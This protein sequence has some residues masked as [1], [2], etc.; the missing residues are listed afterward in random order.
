MRRV[1]VYK[2]NDT[3]RHVTLK[4][5]SYCVDRIKHLKC[6]HRLWLCWLFSCFKSGFHSPHSL[7][8]F[9]VPRRL[10]S[11]RETPKTKKENLNPWP[12]AKKCCIALRTNIDNLV[13][14]QLGITRFWRMSE[15]ANHLILNSLIL[16]HSTIFRND[17]LKDDHIP[18][19]AHYSIEIT[20]IKFV[21]IVLPRRFQQ[22]QS[23]KSSMRQNY[24]TR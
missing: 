24:L 12:A 21:F 23:N 11:T 5:V 1:I 8:S 7:L 19:F 4:Q 15:L 20:C 6:F 17:G 3:T 10:V 2:Y 16:K 13:I 18:H 14:Q 9:V 22:F